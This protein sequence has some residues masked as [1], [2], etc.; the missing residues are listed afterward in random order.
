MHLCEKN[1][2]NS[3]RFFSLYERGA[4][5][6][7]SSIFLL[8]SEVI[9]VDNNNIKQLSTPQPLQHC[10]HQA[11]QHVEE[12]EV[13]QQSIWHNLFNI[14]K[15]LRQKQRRQ[16]RW[17]WPISMSGSLVSRS[18]FL[19]GINLSSSWHL[20]HFTTAQS[21]ETGHSF[22]DLFNAW[23]AFTSASRLSY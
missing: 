13:Q 11:R 21:C 19:P 6:S 7:K 10:D 12:K 23:M 1:L 16:H 18:D 15:L 5:K 17:D 20:Y 3:W 2:N 9:L 8:C 14:V 22:G 4:V